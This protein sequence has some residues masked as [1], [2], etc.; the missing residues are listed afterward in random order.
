MSE[1]LVTVNI[2]IIKNL[3]NFE[4]LHIEAGVTTPLREGE[5]FDDGF[6]RVYSSVERNLAEKIEEAVAELKK[7]GK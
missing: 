7:I 6:S 2:K 3:G 4:S 5:L 1:T